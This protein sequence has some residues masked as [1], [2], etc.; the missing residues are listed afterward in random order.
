MALN[1]CVEDGDCIDFAV[2]A[3]GNLRP[4]LVLDPSVC[5]GL[6]C[7]ANG[8]F[9]PS[10][11]TQVTAGTVP[12]ATVAPYSCAPDASTGYC[13]DIG[14][15]VAAVGL[16][17]LSPVGN[18]PDLVPAS[19]P[20]PSSCY[21]MNILGGYTGREV[22]YDNILAG[23]LGGARFTVEIQGASDLA[24]TWTP[25]SN[26]IVDLSNYPDGELQEAWAQCSGTGAQ[27][28]APSAT[29]YAAYRVMLMVEYEGT[30]G[31]T[32]SSPGLSFGF[33]GVTEI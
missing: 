6:V 21:A 22:Q 30:P 18:W 19:I 33:M 10:L 1:P 2:Q 25:A 32:I 23:G 4:D 12:G 17:V 8:L 14:A 15:F 13:V 16:G 28:L 9:Y 3:N 29:Y 7:G 5:Q 24:F 11:H 26:I 27:V 31:G 20:N